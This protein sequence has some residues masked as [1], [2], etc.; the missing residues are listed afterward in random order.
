[1]L[2]YDRIEGFQWDEGNSGKNDD[3]HGVS[4]GE[5]EQ[6]FFNEPMVLEDPKHS[7]KEPRFH[8]LGSSNEGRFL[9][10]SFTLRGDTKL[11]RVISARPMN[12][13]ERA[14]YAK[15]T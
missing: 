10:V 8:A 12:R 4:D 7:L 3:K 1:M 13:K 14:L 2:D 11:V 5:A 6:V 9:Q 15:E